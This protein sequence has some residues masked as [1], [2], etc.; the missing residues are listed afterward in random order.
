MADIFI[1]YSKA[2]RDLAIKLSAFLEAEGW[3]VWWD[4]SLA[5]A[6]SYRDVIMKE[7]MAARAVISIW[8][9]NSIKSDWVR[10]EA[11]RA[12]AEGK[13]I[14]V[15]SSDVSYADIP[16]PFG[17]MHTEDITATALIR[18][19]LVALLAKPKVEPS[20][21]WIATR[22]LRLQV[23]TWV[24]IIGGSLTLFSNFRNLIGLADWARWIIVHW[25][26]WTHQ[27]WSLV[28]KWFHVTV[29]IAAAHSLSFI[30]FLVLLFTGVA[31]RGERV[32]SW[33]KATLRF[34]MYLAV[35]FVA[36]VALAIIELVYGDGLLG[37]WLPMLS[38][39]EKDNILVVTAV[40]VPAI[41]T[42]LFGGP[43]GRLQ[44][45]MM[46]SMLSIFALI[47]LLLPAVNDSVD[48]GSALGMALVATAILFSYPVAVA[49]FMSFGPVQ[50]LNRRLMFLTLGTISLIVLN[51]LSLLGAQHW[52]EAPAGG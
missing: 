31:L 15:K 46:A 20:G 33:R 35:N 24:G 32:A 41:V 13:L 44:R 51:Q 25:Q 37:S 26:A 42:S 47:I 52:L 5:V 23:L 21:L 34:A 40:I 10:A 16:L 4:K 12:K 29:S 17:E 30:V 43:S 50:A 49:A 11:G 22:T 48:H 3:T 9:P 28:F 27:F 14:P 8:T 18:G 36:F 2:D 7:L 19:A 38:K 1:S 6:D 45:A 39:A